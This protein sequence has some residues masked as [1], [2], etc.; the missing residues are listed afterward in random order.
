MAAQFQLGE[1]VVY[2]MFEDIKN[3][4][5]GGYPPDGRVHILSI[6]VE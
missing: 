3:I 1:I 6:S 5:L 2:V 4:H